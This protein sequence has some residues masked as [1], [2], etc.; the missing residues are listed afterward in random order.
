MVD[1][2]GRVFFRDSHRQLQVDFDDRVSC[3]W[4]CPY[5]ATTGGGACG[6]G[7][8]TPGSH[9]SLSPQHGIPWKRRLAS[10][11]GPHAS[12]PRGSQFSAVPW[13]LTGGLPPLGGSR[14]DMDKPMSRRPKRDE[15][16]RHLPANPDGE[17][18]DVRPGQLIGL[19]HVQPRLGSQASG[20]LVWQQ[21]GQRFRALRTKASQPV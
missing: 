21:A 8:G 13:A 6:S 10:G 3:R 7:L 1:E 2:D 9:W 5:F 18:Y 11:S 16:G 17:G 12:H 15:P 14:P 20:V 4:P 19:I